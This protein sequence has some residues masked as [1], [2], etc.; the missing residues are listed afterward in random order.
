VS[1][2]RSVQVVVPDGVDDPLRPSGGNTYDRRLCQALAGAGWT[3][4]TH[5]VAGDWPRPQQAERRALAAALGGGPRGLPVLV[6]GL[7]ASAA[8]QAVVPA[9]RRVPIVVLLHMPLGAGGHSAASR[10]EAA[11]G[12]RAVLAAA[13]A[14][15]TTSGW[16]RRWLLSTYGLDAARVHVARPGVDAAPAVAA[17]P[18]GSRLLCVGAVVAAKGQ[19]VLLEALATLVDLDWQC[20][21]VGPRTREPAF[22]ERLR[23]RSRAAGV[24]DRLCLTGPLTGA[25]LAAAYAD[26]D[27]LVHPSRAETYGMVV[28]EA[29][30]RALPVVAADAGGVTE[31]LGVTSQGTPPGVL[32]PPGEAAPLAA[33]LR[34]WLTDAESRAVLRAA[35]RRRRGELTGWAETAGRVA[36]VLEGAV[37]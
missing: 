6:D 11:R 19:D 18:D 33:A 9:A 4:H 15:V 26:A 17:G 16:T 13:T 27:L 35:A 32:V 28:T 31:A 34:R 2:A 5:A 36:R 12:E 7:I 25:G 3:V 1:P 22:V 24:G 37:A 21:C 8:P 10:P 30:A 23:D 14:V 29:L 20:V